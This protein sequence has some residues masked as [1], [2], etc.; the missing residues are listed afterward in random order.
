M[1]QT[2]TGLPA[3]F[4]FPA[5]IKNAIRI[6]YDEPATKLRFTGWMRQAQRNTLLTDPSLAA[7]TGI[8]AYQE[9]IGAFF[10]RPRLALKF[11]DPVFIA[12]LAILPA[13]VDFTTLADPALAQRISYNT[14]ERTL[15]VVGILTADERA[16]LDVLSADPDYRNA[17]N[18]LVTRPTLG[19]FPP[20]QLWL[21][22]ADLQFPLRDLTDSANDNL[23]DNLATTVQKGLAYLSRTL[24]DTL[25]IQQASTQLGLTE[26]LTR[27]LLNEYKI[28]PET[29]LSHLTG[30]FATTS[31]AVDY[32]TFPTTFDGWFWAVRVAALWKKWSL[33]LD[34][35]ERVRDLTVGA[36]LLDPLTMPLKATDP[37][38]PT[39]KFVRTSRLIRLRDTLPEDR[40][41]L[42][43]VLQKLG[44][45]SYTAA[46]AGDFAA[47]VELVND[48]WTADDIKELVA[49]L[50]L[51]YPNDYVL[52][53]NWERLR[54]VFYFI[55]SLNAGFATVKTLAAAA[56]T[57]VEAKT[58]K[59]CLRSK[60]G[61]DTWVTLSAEI[62]DALRERKRDALAAYLLT[63]PQP[64]D[65]PTVKW[66]NTNDLYAYYL[67]DV[68]MSSCQLT[69]RLVQG[70]GSIQLF[71]QRCFMGLEP[72][73]AV[74]ADG[75]D[76][77]SAWRW[78]KW[79]RKYRVW[80]A[81]RKIFL[82]PENWIEPEL[83]KDRSTFF[84]DLEKEL[85]QNDLNEDAVE[86]AFTNY[87]EKLKGVAQLEIAGFYQEDDGDD[88][89]IHVFGRTTGAEPHLYYYRRYDYR[90]WTPWEKVDLDIQGD[91]LVPTVIN[92][93]L[94]LVWP[95]FTEVPSESD[96]G[97][98]STPQPNQTGVQIKPAWKKYKLQLAV[99]DYRQGKWTPK[100]VS[101]EFDETSSFNVQIVRKQYEFLAIDRS[102]SDG[103]FVIAY[104]GWSLDAKGD[105]KAWVSGAF[106]LTGCD[107]V[108]VLTD[109]TGSFRPALRPEADSAGD[110]PNFLKW[111]ELPLGTRADYPDE[112]FTL[113]NG[114]ISQK[115][116]FLT[117]VLE[118]TP[119]IYMMTPPW[120]LSYLDRFWTDMPAI[121]LYRLT[122][123]RG[124]LPAGTWLPWFYNDKKRTFFVRPVLSFTSRGGPDYRANLKY[125]AYGAYGAYGTPLPWSS[126]TPMYYPDVKRAFRQWED[127]LSGQVETWVDAL[128]LGAFTPAQRDQLEAELHVQVPTEIAPPYTDD[129]LKRLL[130]RLFM[131]YFDWL[132]GLLSLQLFQWRRFDFK[133][134]YHPLVCDFARTVYNPLK[135]V[136]A[137]MTREVQL[138]DSGFSFARIYQPTW[139]VLEPGTEEYY[140]HENVDFSP[141]GAYS[142]YN[143]E[144]FFHAPLLIANALSR[145]QQFEEARDWY[146]F[147]FNPIGVESAIPGGSAM[148]KYWITKPFFETTDPQYIQQR[149][150]NIMRLLAGDTTVPGYSLQLKQSLEEQVRDWRTYPF[151]PHRIANYRTVAY[152]KTV[153]MKYLDNLI[154]W[155]D[156]LFRQDSMESIN[157]AT[158]LYILAAELLGPKPKRIPPSVKPPLETFN[159][160]ERQLDAFAN[161]LVEVENLVPAQSGNGNGSQSAPIPTLYFCIPRNDKMLGYWDTVA[162]RLYKIRH[163]MNIEGV[164]RQLALFEPP[165]DPGA[166]VKAVA[167]GVDIGAALADLNA[168]LPLY[169]FNVL[170]QKANEVCSDVKA[171]GA[172][173]L[174]ALEKKDA[175]ALSLLRQGQEIQLLEAVKGVRE[176]QLNEAQE[177]LNGLQ[178]TK[179]LTQIKQAYYESREFM[180]V[181]EIAA[182][183]LNTASTA[184]DAGIA[185]GYALAGGL[186]LIPDFL[187][188]ASGF[189]GS[190]HATAQTGGKSFGDSADDLVK[191]LE[192]I[193]HALDKGASIASTVASY[194]R[195]KDEWDFQHD[196]ATKELEQ[197][198]RQI[199]AAE[200]RVSIAQQELDNHNTQIENAKATDAFM[201]SK[202]TNEEL[203]QWQLG[204]ISGTYFQSYKLAYDL[205]KRAERCLR[206]ELGLQDS[207]FISYGYWDSLRK[208]LLSGEKLQYDLRRMETGYLDQN[209]REFE[210]TK[211]ISLMQLD[212][213]ALVKLRET[214]RCFF[215]VPEELLDLDYPGHYLRRIKSVSLTL[216]CVAG[217]YTTISCTLRLLKNSLRIKTGDGDN[218]YPRNTDDNGVPVD[219]DRFVESN[220]PVKAVASSGGQNDSGL[221]DLSFRDERYLPFEGAGAIS[222]WSLELVNDPPSNN[223]DPANPDFG[224][225]LRQFD[226]STISDAVIHIKYT[227]REDAGVFK[228]SAVTHLRDYLSADG[229][230]PSFLALDLRR[231]FPTEWSRF[232]NPVNA[233]VGNVFEFQMSPT[234]FP[235]RDAAKD[236]RINTI[237]LLARAKDPGNYGVTLTP[238]LAAPPPAGA[239]T[240]TLTKSQTYGDLH[241][242]QKDV[243]AAAVVVGTT[244]P[245][246]NWRIKMVRPGG[247]NLTQDP[248]THEMEIADAVL[249]LG[250]EWA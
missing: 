132:L 38:A 120:H 16:A 207:N 110:Y 33:T 184:I 232:L 64:A 6:R 138:Q 139:W 214:G 234:L 95:I 195:R 163:C 131:R 249:V 146:H 171:L 154:S 125:D 87:L 112:D 69:S 203:F 20:E 22:D 172:A 74:H 82:W 56:M 65:A 165:I 231:E 13:A 62:Q 10:Q 222:D 201:R 105:S 136:P 233:A 157:E 151:E 174:S 209:R 70:S 39:D 155:G 101:K 130:V 240:M 248:A 182:L 35:W 24:S 113:G 18:S 40:M 169:R 199:A 83:K 156:Y 176:T 179:V 77:D 164:V 236:L 159:E 194:T 187:L 189:G 250:Y 31:A 149:I 94:F 229:T 218:G 36:K 212:P 81:N 175:E 104:T 55:D 21:Q 54:R 153:V 170:L 107:G 9:A 28:L 85:L 119:G 137:L 53:E 118:Q 109:F 191:T 168:P 185:T 129:E 114:L 140:P 32:A 50:D 205:A 106:E 127:F 23:K 117:P 190:P 15:E 61:S 188:G 224:K 75:G 160:L 44:G 219:D 142:P 98:T 30:S 122:G 108:P 225:P 166:L 116:E 115:S 161:A 37:V 89:L 206:F 235:L 86:T 88:T 47:D 11:L 26:G 180:N 133:N 111:E 3:G 97:T 197:I 71:V 196:L 92:E 242:A 99:S 84:K 124:D 144:L 211:H 143:W 79:M 202:Y 78:W 12:P 48:A 193:A 158:Q 25:V 51:N 238:P 90:Q 247:G 200:L 60:L 162:D 19:V 167:A 226:Y 246:T 63:L 239:N 230:T 243:A 8:A 204:E 147:I 213:L 27:R 228:N 52:A 177:N 150:E 72:D 91:Y 45:G 5:A 244:T 223:P 58:L 17:V 152:Q 102:E 192:S 134:F 68:E 14:E 237:T 7:V 173:L 126:T 183:A 4:D 128:N 49:S 96:N 46:D 227:A 2:T 67:L 57:D 121:L 80:E 43:E 217:P 34:D 220:V 1:E 42:L 215:H 100:R 216:P 29:L 135:G 103:R 59:D 208:G 181:G 141:D 241:F 148:S 145:N 198:D 123:Q 221:F 245:P 93:R 73:V 76:G 186:K 210:L 178:K 66:E 41:T